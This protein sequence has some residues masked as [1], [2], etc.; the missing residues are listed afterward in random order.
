M[1]TKNVNKKILGLSMVAGMRAMAALSLLSQYLIQHPSKKLAK[2][3]LNFLQTQKAANVFKFLATG[4]VLGDKLPFMPPRIKPTPLMARALT[5]LIIGAALTGTK[6]K[7]VGRGATLGFAAA[8][9]SSY[10]FYLIRKKPAE[11]GAL[12]NAIWGTFEDGLIL[13]QGQKLLS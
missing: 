5:G 4:E 8:I 3:P 7:A 12:Q 10:L 6:S 1:K 9:A 11:K 2:T 13:R